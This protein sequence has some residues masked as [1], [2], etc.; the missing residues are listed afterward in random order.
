MRLKRF[1]CMLPVV[2]AAVSLSAAAPVAGESCDQVAPGPKLC[3]TH[4]NVSIA[5]VRLGDPLT[6]V[7]RVLGTPQARHAGVAGSGNC[8]FATKDEYKLAPDVRQY[9]DGLSVKLE[10][11]SL[12]P[13]ICLKHE[14]NREET[15]YDVVTTS[16]RDVIR[17]VHVGSSLS[18]TKQQF[19]AQKI[20][21]ILGKGSAAGSGM[22]ILAVVK[23]SFAAKD[24]QVTARLL[25]HIRHTKVASVELTLRKAWS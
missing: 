21:C 19:R 15:V 13:D 25:F 17:R 10:R 24:T 8:P 3:A 9:V 5:G 12:T 2:A 4:F 18:S 7:N 22:C 23:P 20:A 1:A 16:P 14:R 6:K 11:Y